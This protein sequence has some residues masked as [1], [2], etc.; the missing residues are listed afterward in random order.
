M[1]LPEFCIR[2]PVAATVMVLL[3]VVFGI[4]GMG[5]LGILLHPDVDFPNVTVS[6]IWQNARPEEVDNN[7]T[8]E[9]ED[10]LGGI[11]GVKH[12]YSSSYQ[13]ISQTIIEFELYKD[14]D[15]G[16]QEVRDKVTQKL[17]D[18][19]ED[20]EYPVIDK[21]DLNAQPIIWLAL[22]GQ[23]PPEVLTDY[24][25]KTIKPLLQKL[26]GVG[27]VTII[28]REREV[29][30]WINRDRLATYNIGVD[31][32]IEAV[33]AQHIEVPGGKVES[34]SKEAIVR[35]LSEFQTEDAFN[36]LI[37][38]YRHGNPIR[39]DDIG[40]AE[41][42][43]E[44]L[45]T[46]ARYFD[47]KKTLKAV[48][49]G[50]APR[51]GANEVDIARLVRK[52]VSIIR[53]VLPGGMN[54]DIASDDTVFVEDSI[55][56]VKLQLVIGG[57]MAAL[58]VFLFLQ[59]IR[60]TIFT[61]IAIPTSI[62]STFAAIYAFG[63]TLNNLTM[64]ALITAVGLVIDDSIIM[65]ENI[66]RHRFQLKKGAMQA[67]LEGSREIGFAV[68]AATLTLAGVFLPVA[69]MGGIVGR[70]FKEFALTLAFAVASS[71]F[72]ALTIEPMIAA[73]F[74]KPGGE[75]I[76]IFHIFEYGMRKG[77]DLYR[78]ILDWLLFHRWM[79]LV[80]V[81][82]ALIL[83]GV[84]LKKVG[85]E[86]LASD[87]RSEFVI[88]IETPLSYS[89]SKTDTVMKRVEE[90]VREVPAIK[91]YLA[92]SG[93]SGQDVRETNKGQMR[94]TLLPKS[95]RDISQF[96]VMADLRKKIKEIP[97]VNAMVSEISV[98]GSGMRGE[99]IQFVIQGPDLE[100]LDA[101][102]L[103]L[104]DRLDTIPGIV[105]ADR[106]L[107]L[108]KP[109]VRVKID[110]D[111]AAD[112][113]V[114]VKAIADTVGALM[115]G[116]DVVEFK[117]G[118]ESYDVRLRL[119]EEERKFPTDVERLW[120]RT[121]K[122]EPIDLAS[123]VTIETGIG[124]NVINRMD[125]QRAVTIYANLE[126]DTTLGSA[127]KEISQLLA[128]LLPEGY[129]YK[130][131]GESEAFQET[132]YYIAFAF[133][134][135]VVLTYLVLSA[136]FESFIHPLSVMM[137]LPL[138]FVGAFGLLY[139]TGNTFNLLSMLALV[140]LVGLPTKNGILLVDL[141]NQLRRR[142]LPLKDALVE[143]AGIRLRP[144][145]M[146]AVST[147]AGVIPVALGIGIGSEAR[148]PMAIAIAGGM[149][150]S[151]PLTLLVLPIV[152]SYLDDIS[153]LKFFA[154]IKK[155]LWAEDDTPSI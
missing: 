26:K 120:L 85:K 43:R 6:T 21:L 59:N 70:F 137:G 63:F 14:V 51:S 140:L 62:I 94:V 80:L 154:K 18:L 45:V 123:F 47:G 116:I 135:A 136:Q 145:L 142:G 139:V 55:N 38:A 10:A 15:V 89:I 76:R 8:D 7:I 129:T 151:T 41:A 91:N 128:E 73:R 13:G 72:V 65:E 122:G 42:G 79:V 34:P 74:L 24:A 153:R 144:I 119:T 27:N 66:Y 37:V 28:G 92:F 130:Y 101:L 112:V 113:G 117:S 61:S 60:T 121:Q 87:D 110:R 155:R 86:F 125:R 19:P 32:V 126:G 90:I 44:D 16:A 58:V 118:G 88:R 149:F 46:Q 132:V 93:Y 97:D 108:G 150:S 12:I 1:F 40:Y 68:I 64:L 67:A 77:R 48:G 20:A 115:G 9:I 138:S 71:M 106:T 102:S 133:V 30:I 111:K 148:Q 23:R 33:K 83:G 31:E 36:Q 147:M 131:I 22:Y 127:Q 78:D 107:E 96:D 50:V 84:F 99:E 103:E 49:I 124:P 134:L 25:D 104:L 81:A 141:T 5:R 152:Y 3:L 17:Y 35:T 29:K 53:G 98:I 69:F 75:R 105:D 146:T 143:A 109:E 11:Q 95:E 39:I 114:R 2:K 82:V 4:V 56:E 52:E 100:G 54:I 57:I